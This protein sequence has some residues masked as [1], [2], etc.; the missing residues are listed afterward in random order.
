MPWLSACGQ[1]PNH[2]PKWLILLHK[3][4]VKSRPWVGYTRSMDKKIKRFNKPA[5]P[6]VV[7]WKDQAK[8]DEVRT[9]HEAE[10]IKALREAAPPAELLTTLGKLGIRL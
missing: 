7:V 1:I 4:I 10:A 2:P 5:A 8:L 6:R 3:K 9:R